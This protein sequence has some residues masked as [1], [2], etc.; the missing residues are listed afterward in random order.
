M[1]SACTFLRTFSAL[2]SMR[3]FAKRESMGIKNPK[4]ARSFPNA[5]AIG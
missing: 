5:P 3:Y 4:E 2:F 1:I